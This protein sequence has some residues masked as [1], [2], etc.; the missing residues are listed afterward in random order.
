LFA[1]SQGCYAYEEF[2]DKYIV[3][4][5]H[6]VGGKQILFGFVVFQKTTIPLGHL[7]TGFQANLF[8][9]GSLL[10]HAT[11]GSFT[12]F[13][14]PSARFFPDLFAIGLDLF[15]PP[16]APLFEP[17]FEVVGNITAVLT[18]SEAN[19]DGFGAAK[20]AA[21]IDHFPTKRYL[22]GTVN[23]PIAAGI[24]ERQIPAL[25]GG[26][27]HGV[28]YIPIEWM[29]VIRVGF[30][31]ICEDELVCKHP[32]EFGLALFIEVKVDLELLAV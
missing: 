21:R 4:P 29:S 8:D 23:E 28:G 16:F 30:P 9:I 18:P 24:V 5:F 3:D 1:W 22:D 11:I 12:E 20:I 17:V 31:S 13:L 32:A 25:V 7:P 10:E 15:L 6:G 27:A 2:L 19:L 26:K 14:S